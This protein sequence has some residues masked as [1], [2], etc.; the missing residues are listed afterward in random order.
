MGEEKQAETRCRPAAGRR[1]AVLAGVAALLLFA[2]LFL[3]F[4]PGLLERKILPGLAADYGLKLQLDVRRLGLF[5]AD[6]GD[7]RLTGED[8]KM[9]FIDSV[10]LDYAPRLSGL[11]E[12][13]LVVAGGEITVAVQADGSFRIAGLDGLMLPVSEGG[14]QNASTGLL[15]A[16]LKSISIR[17]LI[18][19][20][21]LPD[22][23]LVLPVRA[24]LAFAADTVNLEL[25]MRHGGR[26]S[27]L[28]AAGR[29]YPG[30]GMAD[31]RLQG[32]LD[33]ALL[34]ELPEFCSPLALDLRGRL[35]C[36]HKFT[37]LRLFESTVRLPAGLHH[38]ALELGP[39]NVVWDYGVG[40]LSWGGGGSGRITADGIGQVAFSID[41]HG[42][43]N[44]APAVKFSLQGEKLRYALPNWQFEVPYL[45]VDGSL[46][47]VKLD[48]ALVATPAGIPPLKIGRIAGEFPLRQPKLLFAELEMDGRQLGTAEVAVEVGDRALQLAGQYQAGTLENLRFKLDGSIPYAGG[49][50]IRLELNLPTWQPKE[51]IRPAAYDPRLDPELTVAGTFG[52]GGRVEILGSRITAGGSLMVRDGRVAMPGASLV[53]EDIDLDLQCR[54]LLNLRTDPGQKLRV[55]RVTAGKINLSDLE[56]R[57]Q[58]DSPAD[59]LLETFQAAWC[60]G[61]VTA[62][63]LRLGSAARTL[64]THIYCDRLKISKVLSELGIVESDGDGI[65][66][67]RIPISLG[68]R[69]LV[70]D[71]GYLQSEPGVGSTL[72]IRAADTLFDS[73]AAGGAGILQAEIA[74]E[75][76]KHFQYDWAKLSMTTAEDDFKVKMQFN[77]K[78]L[79]PLPFGQN[80]QTGQLVRTEGVSAR[81]QGLAIDLNI[82]LPLNR[83]LK[84]NERLNSL[85]RPTP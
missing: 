61:A 48:T 6:L 18:L 32:E 51:P 71:G 53:A 33:R 38:A 67:G 19:K 57:F 83:L 75:A 20:L 64:Q 69:G 54:D 77:G 15:P 3:L 13:A 14:K 76:L 1:L 39:L 45:K 59:C 17:H 49:E 52:F 26:R 27:Q 8:G 10:R 30:G 41:G 7:L 50:P 44:R 2:M 79:D 85:R 80:P 4:L 74:T 24:E 40:P 72:K 5:G 84:I 46:E 68:R 82:I 22:R 16:G 65:V 66:S 36:N 28:T 29:L 58:L 25:E 37:D 63:A 23:R 60:E 11:R 73:V 62:R 81:F 47:A 56:L 78:P 42:E 9:L 35:D 31:F 55:G 34:P 43:A 12:I 70:I 21:E